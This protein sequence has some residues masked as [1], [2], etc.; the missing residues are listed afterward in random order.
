MYVGWVLY[1]LYMAL[2]GFVLNTVYMYI[3]V[4]KCWM[5]NDILLLKYGPYLPH[6]VKTIER[7]K[8]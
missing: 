7:L 4:L 5:F 3:S 2:K 8:H 6:D 1:G